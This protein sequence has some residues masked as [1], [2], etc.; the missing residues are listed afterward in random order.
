MKSSSKNFGAVPMTVSMS[1]R[2]SIGLMLLALALGGFAL[3]VHIEASHVGRTS[4][5]ALSSLVTGNIWRTIAICVLLLNLKAL[6]MVWHVS[7][8]LPGYNRRELLKSMK[9]HQD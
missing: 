1:F 9:K 4:I 3:A 2:M 8:F 5:Q 7:S 6:P